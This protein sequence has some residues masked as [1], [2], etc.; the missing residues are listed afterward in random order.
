MHICA[1]FVHKRVSAEHRSNQPYV[2][3]HQW[4]GIG[5]ESCCVML[6][7]SPALWAA[8]QAAVQLDLAHFLTQEAWHIAHLQCGRPDRSSTTWHRASSSGAVNSPNLW[9]PFRSPRA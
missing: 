6:Q 5:H 8:W 3:T 1:S 4:S 9:I 2:L 7:C